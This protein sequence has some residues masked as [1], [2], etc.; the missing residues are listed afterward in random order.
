MPALQGAE[1]HKFA[2]KHPAGNVGVQIH[3]IDPVNKG[4]IVWTVNVQAIILRITHIMQSR[5]P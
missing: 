1:I 2:G 3:H 5:R 4:E